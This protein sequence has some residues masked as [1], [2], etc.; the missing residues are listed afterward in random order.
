MTKRS[1]AQGANAPAS[2]IYLIWL[3]GD[4]ALD[5]RQRAI[6]KNQRAVFAAFEQARNMTADER[7]GCGP[8]AAASEQVAGGDVNRL[9]QCCG[10]V[11]NS[12]W[13]A[14]WTVVTVR[15]GEMD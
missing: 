3:I 9:K 4:F 15:D 1:A 6:G 11:F 10:L 13:L 8:R 12:H 2:S 7:V 5:L 14:I